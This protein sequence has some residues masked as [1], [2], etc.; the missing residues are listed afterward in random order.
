[1]STIEDKVRE[2]VNARV[3]GHRIIEHT[4]IDSRL[5]ALEERIAMLEA[6]PILHERDEDGHW[7]C[8]CGDHLEESAPAELRAAGDLLTLV[9][10]AAIDPKFRALYGQGELSAP[11]W[12][13]TNAYAKDAILAVADWLYADGWVSIPERIRAQLEP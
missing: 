11:N 9:R 10:D 6:R 4:T 8:C 13:G 2:I 3:V 7:I 12:K 5:D 1:M